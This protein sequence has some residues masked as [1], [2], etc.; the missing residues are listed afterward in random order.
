[1]SANLFHKM[2]RNNGD[3]NKQYYLRHTNMFG[4]LPK[5]RASYRFQPYRR[6]VGMG[7]WAYHH[8]RDCRDVFLYYSLPVMAGIHWYLAILYIFPNS[9]DNT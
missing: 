5:N 1:M 4:A 2:Y 7:V 8:F 3:K 9:P 6:V